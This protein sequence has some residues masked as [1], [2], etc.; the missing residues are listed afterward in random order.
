MGDAGGAA[1]GNL[2][3]IG[4]TNTG[5]PFCVNDAQVSSVS[6]YHQFC[7]GANALGGGLISYNAYGGASQL[8]LNFNINGSTYGFPGPGNGNVAGPASSVAS[9]MVIFNGTGG[10]T[11]QDAS[12]N[13]TVTPLGKDTDNHVEFDKTPSPTNWYGNAWAGPATTTQFLQDQAL[14]ANISAPAYVFQTNITGN[15]TIASGP[16][17][18][19]FWPGIEHVVFKSGDGSAQAFTVVGHLGPNGP[20]DYSEGCE[21]CGA[22]YNGNAAFGYESGVEVGVYDAEP[23]NLSVTKETL[24]HGVIGRVGKYDA[25]LP[26]T[27]S[28]DTNS[29]EAT[30]EGTQ[31]VGAILYAYD[32]TGNGWGQGIDFNNAHIASGNVM[33]VPNNTNISWVK[34]GTPGTYESGIQIN[35][36]DVLQLGYGVSGGLTPLDVQTGA[37]AALATSATKGFF[38]LPATAGTPTGTPANAAAGAIACV[39]DTSSHVLNCYD[40]PASSWYHVALS[41]GAG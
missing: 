32:I 25:T 9:A 28:A 35:A 23:S 18:E 24:L 8:G 30:S 33:I 17:S 36:S 40:Q 2:T 20:S 14:G 4:I 26:S 5:T 29:L 6:G 11:I 27:N 7:V 37:G 3:E 38:F 41:S 15:G 19:S 12:N 39:Y 22:W 16:I 34:H 13:T 1:S 10:K 31:P 21:F